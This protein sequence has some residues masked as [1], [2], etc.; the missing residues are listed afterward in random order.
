ML[1]PSSAATSTSTSTATTRVVF[2]TG[3]GLEPAQRQDL[4]RTKLLTL[5]DADGARVLLVLRDDDAPERRVAQHLRKLRVGHALFYRYECPV[6][7]AR[8]LAREHDALE[9]GLASTAPRPDSE[10]IPRGVGVAALIGRVGALSARLSD[11]HDDPARF[12]AQVRRL[13]G[14]AGIRV[15]EGEALLREGLRL[16][17]AVGRGA[18][19]APRLIL[20]EHRGDPAGDAPYIG[21]AGKG[22]TFDS[23][24]L[25]LKA[26]G[27]IEGMHLDKSGA[28]AV[29]GAMLAARAARAPLNIVAALAMAENAIGPNACK[30]GEVVTAYNGLRV[31]VG[32]TDAEGRLVLGDALAFLQRYP[33]A[34]AVNVATLTGACAAALG[35]R[36]GGLFS[37][38]DALA[39]QLRASGERCDEPLWRMPLGRAHHDAIQSERD[40]ADITNSG[41][42]D[43]GS[44][45]TAAAFLESFV[46]V[47]WAHLDV[48][49]PAMKGDA[50]GF[51]TQ[52]LADFL[53]RGETA[54]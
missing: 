12:E 9:W 3:E 26:T 5:Y 47:P 24:G 29:L 10:G 32:N 53:L 13:W 28:C 41:K 52:L 6:R 49:G 16:V 17:H 7:L 19:V 34:L 2:S 35:K 33:L 18:R 50:R 21:L 39:R 11:T 40:D 25:N 23:G 20:L 54:D 31:E 51:G 1:T 27:H 14:N 42:R 48:A 30:P 37:N 46:R 22:I 43:E 36:M 44:A 4:R 8:I 38:D 45:S 15:L